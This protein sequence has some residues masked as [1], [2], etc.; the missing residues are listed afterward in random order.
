MLGIVSEEVLRAALSWWNREVGSYQAMY[1]R[2]RAN[3]GKNA[4]SY[5]KRPAKVFAGG[6]ARK[7]ELIAKANREDERRVRSCCAS[8][9]HAIAMRNLLELALAGEGS[10]STYDDADLRGAIRSYRTFLQSNAEMPRVQDRLNQM[11]G[12][13]RDRTAESKVKQNL[14][15]LAKLEEVL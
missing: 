3:V 15:M 14:A 8:L 13:G 5:R 10:R 7:R 6:A 1:D 12:F 4:A 2:A 9:D 11:F